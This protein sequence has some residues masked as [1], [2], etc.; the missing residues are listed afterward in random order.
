MGVPKRLTGMQRKF[1]ELIVLYEGRKFDYECAIEAGYSENRSRQ[2]ASELQNPEQ[3]PLVVKYI[4]D[5][6]EEQRNRFKVNYGRHVTELAR[7]RDQALKHRSFSAAA[8]AEHM[9]GKAGGL[10][11]EQKHILHG[12]L[13]DDK[14]EEE[15][16][17][18][19]ADLLKS[20]RKIINITPEEVID[21]ESTT[22]DREPQPVLSIRK[23]QS[24]QGSTS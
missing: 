12:K 3:S 23:P 22:E 13:D 18:E 8:N 19:I 10:Y 11:V 7:I 15:M 21:V 14:N 9:R 17:K 24:D 20:N 5:L 16:N 2:E 4:G 1:A 6:R